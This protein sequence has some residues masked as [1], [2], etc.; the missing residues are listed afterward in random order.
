MLKAKIQ[1]INLIHLKMS[2]LEG[3]KGEATE[4]KRV[5]HRAS[6]HWCGSEL[7]T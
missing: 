4:L 1:I 6:Q 2:K 3:K 7:L 5:I